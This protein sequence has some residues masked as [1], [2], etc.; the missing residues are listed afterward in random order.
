[1]LCIIGDLHPVGGHL[2]V[3]FSAIECVVKKIE[4]I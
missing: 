1:M 3:V 2:G 4:L